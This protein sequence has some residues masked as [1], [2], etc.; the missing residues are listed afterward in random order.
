MGP[1][2]PAL[3]KAHDVVDVSTI[4]NL[5]WHIVG[6]EGTQGSYSLWV[7]IWHSLILTQ[8]RKNTHVTV[9]TY[10]DNP[11]RPPSLRQTD[12]R[13]FPSFSFPDCIHYLGRMPFISPGEKY[14]FKI[15]NAKYPHVV[16]ECWVWWLHVSV[17]YFVLIF[18]GDNVYQ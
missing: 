16:Q 12:S 9:M 13:F 18:R 5:A 17:L 3:M 8:K 4:K 1:V 14:C 7:M 2:S 15:S 10:W 11:L 6:T